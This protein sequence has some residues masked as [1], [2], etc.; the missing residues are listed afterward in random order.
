MERPVFRELPLLHRQNLAIIHM[1]LTKA[2]FTI[3]KTKPPRELLLDYTDNM[4]PI[5]WLESTV[6]KII[7]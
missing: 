1:A 2:T 5:I 4:L 3:R 6:R 7:Y